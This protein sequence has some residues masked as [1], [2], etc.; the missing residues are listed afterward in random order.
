MVSRW[1]DR[2][3][4]S[5]VASRRD[6]NKRQLLGDEERENKQALLNIMTDDSLR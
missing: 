2:L 5:I 4:Y 6:Q 3:W 1:V